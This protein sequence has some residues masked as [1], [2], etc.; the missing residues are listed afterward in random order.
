VSTAI[1]IYFPAQAA[2]S[3]SDIL[4]SVGF[5]VVSTPRTL[6]SGAAGMEHR[7]TIQGHSFTLT[8]SPIPNDSAYVYFLGLAASES[9]TSLAR[10]RD[11]LAEH[12]AIDATRYAHETRHV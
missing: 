6:P 5:T 1:D 4:G 9:A 8:E 12:G 2:S 3:M 11:I 7:C 10:A